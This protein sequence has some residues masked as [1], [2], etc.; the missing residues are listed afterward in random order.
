[1]TERTDPSSSD[2]EQVELEDAVIGWIDQVANAPDEEYRMQVAHA[3]LA[4]GLAL[5][6]R[7]RDLAD[8]G[9]P[10]AAMLGEAWQ[11]AVDWLRG[12]T[13][14]TRRDESALRAQFAVDVLS[15]APEGER[16]EVVAAQ[17][18]LSLPP[19]HPL[20]DDVQ[21]IAVLRAGAE[22]SRAEGDVDGEVE[23]I[24]Q[25]LKDGGL[26]EDEAD[27]LDDRAVSIVDGAEPYSAW[28]FWTCRAGHYAMRASRGGSRSR[29]WA[30][31]ALAAARTAQRIAEGGWPAETAMAASGDGIRAIAYEA[32][33]RL[34]VAAALAE[35][36]VA[37]LV[38]SSAPD[39]VPDRGDLSTLVQAGVLWA[40][41]NATDLG[42]L[43]WS[44]AVLRLGRC[45]D[46]DCC[47][48]WA[49]VTVS[50]LVMGSLG[51][52]VTHFSLDHPGIAAISTLDVDFEG[53][54]V[55]ET[56]VVIM[57]IGEGEKSPV[58]IS[59]TG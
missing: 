48:G 34:E 38:A 20:R 3:L 52:E 30:K 31:V 40:R 7:L 35:R 10:R 54:L 4:C 1:M 2:V 28:R 55:Q 22:R 8:D 24:G 9:D 56:L 6:S 58:S 53:D 16:I 26:T 32:L 37:P 13:L 14:S 15:E 45:C 18:L 51:G 43:G 11:L 41:P 57:K 23:A 33:G 29:Q 46:R 50:L 49:T 44:L 17:T 39:G 5:I 25:L 36:S 47:V 27:R 12:L 21:A 19:T 59:W 42:R